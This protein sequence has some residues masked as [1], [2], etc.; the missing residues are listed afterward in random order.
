MIA[1][2]VADAIVDLVETGSTLAAN[3]LRILDE[4]GQ[5]ETVLVQ[6]PATKHER[7]L[8]PRRPPARRR[9]DRP[10]LFAARIQRA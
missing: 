7:A 10:Q 9:G 8:R 6:N 4:I 1:L 3:R 2:G 5:Y